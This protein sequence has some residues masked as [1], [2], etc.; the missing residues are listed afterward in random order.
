VANGDG[1]EVQLLGGAQV[2]AAKGSRRPTPLEMRSEFLHAFLVTERCSR[3]CRWVRRHGSACAPAGLE[4]DHGARQ[5]D[6][7]GPVRGRFAPPARR[8]AAPMSAPRPA[9]PAMSAARWSSSPARPAASA[10][11]WRCAT[12]RAGWRLA[13]VARRTAEQAWAAAQGLAPTAAWSTR[14]DVA[15]P[16]ASSAPAGAASR[17][18]ACPTW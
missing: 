2:T 10:R 4:Y 1:S 11:R 9:E 18:R 6:A 13:L 3:T 12:H 8:T 17:A 14:A 16:T 15:R 5:L 7:G